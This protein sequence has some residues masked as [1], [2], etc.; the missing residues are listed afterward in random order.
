MFEHLKQPL[1]PKTRFAIRFLR[2]AGIAAGIVFCA[3]GIGM[4]GYHETEGLPWLDAM[5]N[6]S[7]L[8]GG[9][10]PVDALHTT[11]GKVFA[12]AY[13]LFAG[14]VFIVTVGVL[15]VPMIHRFL[16][17]FHVELGAEEAGDKPR[18]S[19]DEIA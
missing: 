4:L 17:R 3:L 14:L 11:A 8:L 9:M 18:A 19:T 1:L 7:M 2:H 16:H 13:A 12:S 10:G 6:A 15:F 5:L